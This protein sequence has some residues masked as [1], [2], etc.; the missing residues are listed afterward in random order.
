MAKLPPTRFLY[1]L[2]GWMTKRLSFGDALR[3]ISEKTERQ[4]AIRTHIAE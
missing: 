3:L 2:C 1:I 4:R